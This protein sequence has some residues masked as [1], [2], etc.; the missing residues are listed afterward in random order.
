MACAPLMR[1]AA[2]IRQHE[3]MAL[4]DDCTA[5]DRTAGGSERRGDGR[6]CGGGDVVCCGGRTVSA[7]AYEYVSLN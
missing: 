1:Q 4:V 3:K 2:G 7:C 5:M 6:L